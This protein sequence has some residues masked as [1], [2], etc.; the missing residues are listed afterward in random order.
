MIQK[1][2]VTNFAI[3]DRLEINFS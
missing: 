1:L 3:I 2:L